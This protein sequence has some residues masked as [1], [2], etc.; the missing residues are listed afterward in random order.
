M[1]DVSVCPVMERKTM[2]EN[3]DRR[4]EESNIIVGRNAVQEALNAGVELDKLFVADHR[5]EGSINRIVAAAKQRGIVVKQVSSQKLRAICGS[6]HHQGIIAAASCARYASV[7]ELLEAAAKRGEP[8]FLI[9]ADGVE[10]PH[11]L[12]ALIR[13]AE[14]AGAHGLII[15]KRRSAS[16]TPVVQK[17]SAGAVNHLPVAR[18]SNLAAAM[19]RLKEA[20]LWFYAAD[21]E[22]EPWCGQDYTGP[23]GLVVGSE[24][25][26]VSRL[27]LGKCDFRV[28]LPMRGKV[29][30]LNASVAGGILM[31]EIARQRM[32]IKAK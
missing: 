17:T 29:T 12:G 20:G 5:Q 1:L 24:G 27:V 9:L 7:E 11:N 23:C 28:S 13:T 30:S 10:D 26:G 14:A 19:E 6:D 25:E 8:P 15:P 18:V 2:V 4:T 3:K 22:G 31:Y 21:M 32:R 16:L